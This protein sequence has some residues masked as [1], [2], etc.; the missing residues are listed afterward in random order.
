M[1]LMCLSPGS[2]ANWTGIIP[3]SISI[4]SAVSAMSLRNRIS[5]NKTLGFKLTLLYSGFFILIAAFLFGL[6]YFFMS[7]NL[8]KDDHQAITSQLNE[9]YA[10]YA[11]GGLTQ[12]TAQ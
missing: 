12:V 9:T 8:Q 10:D 7:R 5:G 1:W 6:A 11:E 2:G 4:P 3:S